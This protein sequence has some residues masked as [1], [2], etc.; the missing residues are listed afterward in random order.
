VD[1]KGLVVPMAGASVGNPGK[2]YTRNM[3]RRLMDTQATFLVFAEMTGGRAYYNS[4][5]LVR[6]FRDAVND[7]A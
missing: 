6:G 4:N 5:D 7:S 1:V 3:N 2:N